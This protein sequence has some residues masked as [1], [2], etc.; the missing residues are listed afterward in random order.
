M[1]LWDAWVQL[2]ITIITFLSSQPGITESVAIV[3]FTFCVRLLLFP[4]SFRSA[5][6]MIMNKRALEGIRP[7]IEKLK[8]RYKNDPGQL[9]QKTMELYRKNN[10]KLMDRTMLY[11]A[12]LQGMIGLGTFQALKQLPFT[13][14]FLWI[15]NIAKPDVL[16]AV[17]VGL[18]SLCIMLLSPGAHEQLPMLIT[19]AVIST[20]VLCSFPSVIGIYWATSNL[21]STLQA[22]VLRVVINRKEAGQTH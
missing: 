13:S 15:E 3:L 8:E 6:N 11:N 14:K 19:M 9:T 21:V 5:Y 22:L 18:L 4:I 10:I 20:I 7:K 17:I 1:A 12:G 16:M 2:I